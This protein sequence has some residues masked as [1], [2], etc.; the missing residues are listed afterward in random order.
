MHLEDLTLIPNNVWAMKAMKVGRSRFKPLSHSTK[1]V[2]HARSLGAKKKK[3]KTHT[4]TQTG[5]HIHLA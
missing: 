4:R 3:I 5:L 2:F 1:E